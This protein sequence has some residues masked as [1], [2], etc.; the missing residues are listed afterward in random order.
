MN[1]HL[2]LDRAIAQW[3]SMFHRLRNESDEF[4]LYYIRTGL[5]APLK[6]V[7]DLVSFADGAAHAVRS[8]NPLFKDWLAVSY[9]IES[10]LSVI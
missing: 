10:Y 7:R 5:R 9:G 2:D 6:S 8:S 4:D 3:F 1:I